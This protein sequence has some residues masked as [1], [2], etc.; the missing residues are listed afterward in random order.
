MDRDRLSQICNSMP[1]SHRLLVEHLQAAARHI[2]SNPT[3][4]LQKSNTVLDI[5]VR[6]IYKVEMKRS[7]ASVSIRMLLNHKEFISSIQPRRIYLLMN[8]VRNMTSAPSND[9]VNS[10]SAKIVLE[11][12]LDIC[13]WYVQRLRKGQGRTT[14]SLTLGG[15]SF[16]APVGILGN[17]L[18]FTT[19]EFKEAAKWFLAMAREGDAS[20]QYNLGT[21]YNHGR[22]V[23]KDYPE[24][25]SWYRLA[26]QQGNANACYALGV[27]YQLGQ[28][29]DRDET[30]A[31]RLYETAAHAGNAAAQYNLGSLYHHGNGVG[32]DFEEAAKW[33]RLAADQGNTSAFNNLGFLY[34]NG[35]GAEQSY[36]KAKELFHRAAEAGD[37]SAQ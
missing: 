35:T 17:D 30:E 8:L 2:I 11:Y 7:A 16:E 25:A 31:A 28:G 3:L 27:L 9:A 10:K 20:A 5:T 12:L 34:H 1:H 21:L 26:A 6:D 22:G 19:D 4:S 32:Q 14:L 36:E 29:V 24:A 37:S 13:E 15:E 23:Q 18:Q 33:Y